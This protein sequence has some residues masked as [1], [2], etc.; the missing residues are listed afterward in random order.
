MSSTTYT[1]VA[2][3]VTHAAARTGVN[4]VARSAADGASPSG[5]WGAIFGITM[6]LAAFT[7]ALFIHEG[8]GAVGWTHLV[9]PP[10]LYAN[11]LVLLLGSF[12]LWMASRTG[13]SNVLLDAHA[14]KS[15]MCWLMATL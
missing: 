4:I 12:T 14:V 7:S 2:I 10:I 5:A 15:V 1:P 3:P 13:N 8:H 6:S 9:L 11:T